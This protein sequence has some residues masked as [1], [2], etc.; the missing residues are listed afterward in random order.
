MV[1]TRFAL[2]LHMRDTLC[3]GSIYQMQSFMH[4]HTKQ[5]HFKHFRTVLK[6]RDLWR[7]NVVLG[8]FQIQSGVSV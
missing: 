4:E 2:R 5:K 8:P 3:V 6:V 1:L 7:A